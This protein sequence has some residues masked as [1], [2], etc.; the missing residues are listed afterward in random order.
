[1]Q[2]QRVSK[3]EVFPEE[4]KPRLNRSFL[5]RRMQLR[6]SGYE[7]T[8]AICARIRTTK[9]NDV[10]KR[11]VEI[12]SNTGFLQEDFFSLLRANRDA[13]EKTPRLSV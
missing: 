4:V 1:M 5:G 3:R 7:F 10:R 8:E 9:G 12:F 6:N 13:T 2:C 11:N